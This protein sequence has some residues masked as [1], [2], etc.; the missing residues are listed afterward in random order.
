[1]PSHEQVNIRELIRA[2]RA[3]RD[4]AAVTKMNRLKAAGDA[5]KKVD[6]RFLKPDVRK[7]IKEDSGTY[8][9]VF[10]KA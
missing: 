10:K 2:N 6:T 7:P 4:V 3:T 1:M 9:V 8:S 5:T